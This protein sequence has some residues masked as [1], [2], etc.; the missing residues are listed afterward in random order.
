MPGNDAATAPVEPSS[1][2]VVTPSA[3]QPMPA[4]PAPAPPVP[5]P[6]PYPQIVNPLAT[7]RSIFEGRPWLAPIGAGALALVIGITIGTAIGRR[8]TRPPTF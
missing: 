4:I 3:P 7:A 6:L 8:S 2:P 5:V 1:T